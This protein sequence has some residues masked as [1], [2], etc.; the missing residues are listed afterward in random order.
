MNTLSSLTRPGG[1]FSFC[2]VVLSLV[3]PGAAMA[4]QAELPPPR[5]LSPHVW[6]WIG[7]LGPPSRDNG[8]YRMN[9]GFV[10]G[11]RGIAV[12]DTGY[13]PAMAR[14]MLAHIR[15]V[16]DR[17]VLYA[18]NT[19]SQPHRFM[20][21]GVFRDAG[22]VLVTHPL[23]AARMERLSGQYVAT[24]ER[25]LDLRPDS[26]PFPVLPQRL[27]AD[28]LD[29]DLG[30]VTLVIR[31]LGAAHTPAPL[32]VHVPEDRLVF[33]GDVL[34]GER[35]L[36]VLPDSSVRGWISTFRA[37]RQYGTATFIPGHGQP[38]K[39]AQFEFPTLAYLQRLHTHM[40]RMVD[41]GVDVQDAITR[42]DQRAWSKLANFEQLA[43]RNA[44]WAY[45]EAESA[46]FE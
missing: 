38:G 36:A 16:S 20:G 21:N 12:V 15:K 6:A 22:A 3:V 45:L 28:H 26:L 25:V 40:T 7:P 4:E 27:V 37:L 19:N 34:Y 10:V 9:M 41:E 2:L 46:A 24:I 29:V 5:Q 44:S 30:G 35:L 17:P 18:I 33:A 43:G 8:G 39:L 14:A 42:L 1:I 23:E 11:S 13:T 31:H 32:V